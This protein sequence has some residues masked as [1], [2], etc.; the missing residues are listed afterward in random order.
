LR[1]LTQVVIPGF[2]IAGLWPAA[3]KTRNPDVL[4]LSRFPAI[5]IGVAEVRVRKHALAPRNDSVYASP[6]ISST[7]SF[8]ACVT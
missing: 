7:I 6:A 4:I 8:A 3:A 5:P 2:A 1:L